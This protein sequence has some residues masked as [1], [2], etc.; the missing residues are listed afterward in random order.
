M[1]AVTPDAGAD[2]QRLEL[3]NEF[4]LRA[5][6]PL[7]PNVLCRHFVYPHKLGDLDDS[8]QRLLAVC[9]VLK[10]D[11]PTD[12]KRQFVARA[13]G[14]TL[15]WERHTEFSTFSFYSP[16]G[17]TQSAYSFPDSVIDLKNG[18][19]GVID[20][21]PCV[22][23]EVQFHQI[24]ERADYHAQPPRDV[25]QGPSIAG[26]EACDQ[27]ADI[28]A[29]FQIREDGYSRIWI[30]DRGLGPKRAGRLLQR[31]I[32]VE[33]YRIMAM[34]GLETA[35]QANLQATALEQR[36]FA[37]LDDENLTSADLP[38]GDVLN[39]LLALASETEHM[40]VRSS[41][42]FD[43][44][45]AYAQLVHRR[46]DELNEQ[47]IQGAQR[48]SNFLKRRFIPAVETCQTAQARL[49]NLAARIDRGAALIRTRIDVIR[50]EQN[51]ELL[52]AMNR[53]ATQQFKLQQ[54][55]EAVS[56]IAISYYAI[57]I[58]SVFAKSIAEHW[59]FVT[60]TRLT[61]IAA[62]LIIVGVYLFIRKLRKES[63]KV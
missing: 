56:T 43:A 3:N 35:H 40:L 15:K 37:I 58:F 32:D 34:I 27:H 20:A 7:E 26:S 31:L 60:S 52:D 29:D 42:R 41:F 39:D 5:P 33:T 28:W 50:Q 53:R 8:E 1:Q 12:M 62:P 46:F 6:V 4:H 57:S 17:S 45:K 49:Q 55:V 47:R 18:R 14:V 61:A 23:L 13:H 44:T 22:A 59:S 9:A 11:P 24:E 2:D 16:P 25:F 30:N 51:T 19:I 36:L 10:I 21:E 54:T 38:A 63:E 48:L